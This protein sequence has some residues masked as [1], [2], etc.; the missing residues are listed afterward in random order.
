MTVGSA[1]RVLVLRPNT[2]LFVNWGTGLSIRNGRGHT[3]RG[4]SS[5]E[6]P[7]YRVFGSVVCLKYRQN[8]VT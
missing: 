8:G 1:R 2:V 5:V 4:A 7:L 6:M 3:R